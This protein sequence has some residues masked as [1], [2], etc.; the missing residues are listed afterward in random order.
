MT[1]DALADVRAL[2]TPQ[3]RDVLLG[4]AVEA[5]MPD[6]AAPIDLLPKMKQLAPFQLRMK[7]SVLDGAFSPSR[8]GSVVR[9][10]D[11]SRGFAVF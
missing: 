1:E 11:K 5:L 9:A 7:R 8:L 10:R 6:E 2:L 3:P 4:D